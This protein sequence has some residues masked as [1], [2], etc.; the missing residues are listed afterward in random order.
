VPRSPR[1]AAP[2]AASPAQTPSTYD[3]ASQTGLTSSVGSSAAAVAGRRTPGGGEEPRL[4]AVDDDADVDELL[5]VDARN[6]AEDDVLVRVTRRHR[7]T[8]SQPRGGLET[9]IEELDVRRAHGVG[10]STPGTGSSHASGTWA[11]ISVNT[12][13][14]EQLP[15]AG[16]DRPEVIGLRRL[17]EHV[18]VGLHGCAANRAGSVTPPLQPWWK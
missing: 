10:L 14:V 8:A 12:S 2:T 1:P 18:V 4:L 17:E 3:R 5:T 13:L 15:G 9:G 11:R 6:A 16:V 7:A